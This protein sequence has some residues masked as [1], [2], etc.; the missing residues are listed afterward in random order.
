M[1]ILLALQLTQGVLKTTLGFCF[2]LCTWM[3]SLSSVSEFPSSLFSVS[4]MVSAMESL[5]SK[6]LSEEI[7]GPI[8]PMDFPGDSEGKVSAYNVGDWIWS[9]GCEDL[10]GKEIATHSSTLAWKIPWMEEPDRLQSMGSQ[11]VGH[12]WATSMSMSCILL[13]NFIYRDVS[14]RIQGIIMV[15]NLWNH[16]R[17]VLNVS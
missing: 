6:C 1:H 3:N 9:L 2:S 4:S 7:K 15:Q 16:S 14:N 17:A 8:C 5:L 10:L 13:S 12:N 11:R